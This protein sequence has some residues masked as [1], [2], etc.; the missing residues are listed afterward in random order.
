MRRSI[1][2]HHSQIYNVRVLS[3]GI[4]NTHIHIRIHSWRRKRKF[5][6][7]MG[8]TAAATAANV[9]G[10]QINAHLRNASRMYAYTRVYVTLAMTTD[11]NRRYLC[12]TVPLTPAFGLYFHLSRRR[13]PRVASSARS[14]PIIRVLRFVRSNSVCLIIRTARLFPTRAAYTFV[15]IRPACTRAYTCAGNC[16]RYERD[17]CR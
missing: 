4:A 16:E 6:G 10:R 11:S 12:V 9:L 2:V 1:H 7:S 14:N 17:L 8:G 3:R 15:S 13:H 5:D